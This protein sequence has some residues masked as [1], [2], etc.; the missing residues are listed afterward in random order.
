MIVVYS[1][2]HKEVGVAHKIILPEKQPQFSQTTMGQVKLQIDPKRFQQ[3]VTE[4]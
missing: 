2:D 3:V 1:R 4:F